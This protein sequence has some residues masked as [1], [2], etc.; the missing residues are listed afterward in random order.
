MIQP[1]E[2]IRERF[3]SFLRLVLRQPVG[4]DE[5]GVYGFEA[6]GKESPTLLVPFWFFR[7]YLGL[8]ELI[9][10]Q[11]AISS[12]HRGLQWNGT[13]HPADVLRRYSLD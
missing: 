11:A 6:S 7:V 4:G 8:K 1:D 9:V 5:S 13:P 10:K 12:S 3:R 2:P